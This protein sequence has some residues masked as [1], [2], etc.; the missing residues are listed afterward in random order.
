MQFGC[1]KKNMDELLNKYRGRGKRSRSGHRACFE[2]E[3]RVIKC[4]CPECGLSV[5]HIHRVQCFKLKCPQCSSIMTRSFTE[6]Q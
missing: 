5:P 1:G 6:E 3:G 2:R 4:I